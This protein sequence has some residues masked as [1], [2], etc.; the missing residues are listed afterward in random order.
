MAGGLDDFGVLG[1]DDLLGNEDVE[2]D[3]ANRNDLLSV[4][5]VLAA[6]QAGDGEDGEQGEFHGV[7]LGL[8]WKSARALPFSGIPDRRI[9]RR[10]KDVLTGSKSH[11]CGEKGEFHAWRRRGKV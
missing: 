1:F 5:R 4:G 6:C 3:L 10:L 9:H 11:G 8:G 7:R 2:A